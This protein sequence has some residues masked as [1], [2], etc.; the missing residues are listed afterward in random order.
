MS[1]EVLAR[2]TDPETSHEAAAS[3]S[4]DEINRTQARVLFLLVTYGPMT[5]K[6]LVEQYEA[7][8]ARKSWTMPTDSSIRTRRHELT[9]ADDPLIEFAGYYRKPGRTRQRVWAAL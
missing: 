8:A 7:D 1:T 4:R 6:E 5:D 3:L 2:S 9:V